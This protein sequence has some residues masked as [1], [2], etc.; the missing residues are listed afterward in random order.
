M[1]LLPARVATSRRPGY[2]SGDR[3]RGLGADRVGQT[4]LESRSEDV[5]THGLQ[6]MCIA[7]IISYICLLFPSWIDPKRQEARGPAGSRSTSPP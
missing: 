4:D 5:H 2:R 7:A 1:T 3:I 6:S